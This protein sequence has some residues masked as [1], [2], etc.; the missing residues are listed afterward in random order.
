MKLDKK[1]Q[2][3]IREKV[4]SIGITKV[5]KGSGLA[6]TTVQSVCE[7]GICTSTTFGKLAAYLTAEQK[8]IDKLIEELEA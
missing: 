1:T 4:E 2:D 5:A 7:T 8:K 6:F 3:S